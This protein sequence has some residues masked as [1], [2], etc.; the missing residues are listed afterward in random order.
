MQDPETPV[1]I[2][3]GRNRC[4][5]QHEKEMYGFDSGTGYDVSAWRMAQIKADTKLYQKESKETDRSSTQDDTSEDKS[6]D[7]SEAGD[8]TV[9]FLM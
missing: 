4:E 6:V 8:M 5:K 7:D 3:L 9:H 2:H 1:Y